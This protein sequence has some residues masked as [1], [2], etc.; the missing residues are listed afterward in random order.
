MKRKKLLLIEDSSETAKKLM[1]SLNTQFEVTWVRGGLDAMLLLGHQNYQAL[2]LETNLPDTDGLQVV[3]TIRKYGFTL[4]IVI[5]SDR[6]TAQ[7]RI[8]GLQAGADD[9]LTKPASLQELMLRL[10][11][12]LRRIGLSEEP[13]QVMLPKEMNFSSSELRVGDVIIHRTHRTVKRAGSPI[14]LRKK[15]FELLE[16]LMDRPNQVMSK[17]QI[18]DTLWSHGLDANE[19]RVIDNHLCRLRAKLDGGYEK[20]YISTRRGAGY[21]FVNQEDEKRVFM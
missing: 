16:L 7:D 5:L 15:E 1:P 19:S 2:I 4:P 14:E 18:M 8:A 9:Y 17:Q 10:E 13:S 3:R 6:E 21:T 20:K 12:L 11:I